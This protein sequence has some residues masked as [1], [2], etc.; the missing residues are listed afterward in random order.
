M[1]ARPGGPRTGD[2]PVAIEDGEGNGKDV[3]FRDF[4]AQLV[5][6]CFRPSTQGQMN[7]GLKPGGKTDLPSANVA[8][9]VPTQTSA[10]SSQAALGWLTSWKQAVYLEDG[11][12]ATETFPQGSAGSRGQRFSAF[13]LIAAVIRVRPLG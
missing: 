9:I 5:S 10:P 3:W 13:H 8:S 6:E 7:R 11:T 1:A 12:L 4:A 2:I